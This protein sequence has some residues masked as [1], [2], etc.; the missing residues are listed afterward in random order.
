MWIQGRGGLA[1]GVHCGLGMKMKL[2]RRSRGYKMGRA[3]LAHA[4]HMFTSAVCG[5]YSGHWAGAGAC[6]REGLLALAQAENAINMW[7]VWRQVPCAQPK[8]TCAHG[9][10]AGC[11]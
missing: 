5:V 8:S 7:G 3:D 1:H 6:H 10:N 11:C 4:I 2:D 9:F